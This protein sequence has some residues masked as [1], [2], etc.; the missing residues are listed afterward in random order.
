[1]YLVINLGLKSIRGIVF[2]EDGEQVYAKAFP[3][4]TSIFKDNVE[5]DVQEWMELLVLILGDITSN[6]DLSSSIRVITSTT[7]SSCIVGIDESMEAVTKVLMVSDRRAKLIQQQIIND[8][9]YTLSGAGACPVSSVL[10]KALWFKEHAPEQFQAVRYWFGAGEVLNYYFTKQIITDPLNAGKAFYNGD[11]YNAELIEALGVNVETLPAVYE[12]GSSFEVD[13]GLIKQFKL[14]RDCKYI[15]STYDAICA[16]IGST[17]GAPDNACDVS[18]T[19]TSVRLVGEHAVD[20]GD[21]PLLSQSLSFLDKYLVGSSNNMG[22]GIIEWYKQAFFPER[23]EEVYS[24]MNDQAQ[25]SSPGAGGIVFLPYLLGERAPFVSYNATASFFGVTRTSNQNDFSRAVFESTAYVT[26]DLIQ[27]IE[28]RGCPVNSLTVSGGLARFDLISQIKADVS[29]KP[30]NVVENFESTSIGAFI[31]VA[32]A[33]GKY[34]SLSEASAA[35]VKIRMVIQPSEKNHKIYR[36]YF[37]LFK[38]INQSLSGL[39]DQHKRIKELQGKHSK[40]IM[41]NL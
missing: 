26:N 18:G 37:S 40:E 22:G 38:E 33:D 3:V 35:V 1:M 39:Y 13:A 23:K 15:L 4:H 2:N 24:M 19:V 41:Q 21:T 7:S 17:N 27:L 28:G 34:S 12:V 31:L 36:E 11:R 30:V 14:N 20:A 5:Q 16:V 6:T 8:P 10:P 32:I 25:A 9:A 29:L